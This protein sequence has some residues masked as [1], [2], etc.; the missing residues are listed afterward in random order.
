M[1]FIGEIIEGLMIMIAFW[2][3]WKSPSEI[4]EGAGDPQSLLVRDELSSVHVISHV[5]AH[6]WWVHEE[7]K[8]S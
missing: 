5:S 4:G 2:W 6:F 3:K 8:A 7:C 1:S